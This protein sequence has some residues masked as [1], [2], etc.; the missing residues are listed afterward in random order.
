MQTTNDSLQNCRAPTS[1]RAA[2]AHQI[3]LTY[4]VPRC[5][6]AFRVRT[7]AAP[8]ISAASQFTASHLIVI[9]LGKKVQGIG[10]S[11]K[12]IQAIFIRESYY[13][14]AFKAPLRTIFGSGQQG[15][16]G[17]ALR[18]WLQ[19][20]RVHFKVDDCCIKFQTYPS[21]CFTLVYKN[22]KAWNCSKIKNIVVILLVAIS[23]SFKGFSQKM[24]YL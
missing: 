16:V 2:P 17:G 21:S 18:L 8:T 13:V 22:I 5:V 14:E 4:E 9:S 12:I 10:Q 1:H 11:Y 7:T 19:H 3:S 20:Q 24:T 23:L 6:N 15:V